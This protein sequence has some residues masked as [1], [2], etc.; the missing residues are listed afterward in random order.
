M[1][2]STGQ[3]TRHQNVPN[4]PRTQ[5][6]PLAISRKRARSRWENLPFASAMFSGISLKRDRVDPCGDSARNC[7]EESLIHPQ[8]AIAS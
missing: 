5:F 1:T 8:K 6:E 3:A 4:M 2:L 7:F